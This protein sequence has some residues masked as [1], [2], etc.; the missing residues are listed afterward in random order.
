MLQTNQMLFSMAPRAVTTYD[1]AGG[2]L[3]LL[4][5]IEALPGLK[6]KTSASG[7]SSANPEMQTE[8][9]ALT[10]QLASKD[11]CKEAM[12]D[13]GFLPSLLDLIYN[14]NAESHGT[15]LR[16]DALSTVSLLCTDCESNQRLLRKSGGI[17]VLVPFLRY[18]AKDPNAQEKVV[19]ARFILR[20]K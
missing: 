12:G 19:L 1:E 11:E 3:V 15:G 17:P 13:Y 7:L 4:Q 2:F 8:I 9:L 18:N 6:C 16:T 14:S 10:M 20:C 5:L